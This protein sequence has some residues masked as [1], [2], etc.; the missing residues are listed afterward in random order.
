ERYIR[1][2]HIRSMCKEIVDFLAHEF[3]ENEA[4]PLW[5]PDFLSVQQPLSKSLF[6]EWT[7]LGI[8]FFKQSLLAE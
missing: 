5:L 2:S 3:D 4:K 8:H 1:T 7:T 6:P